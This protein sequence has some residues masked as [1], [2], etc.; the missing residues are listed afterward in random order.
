MH[1][2]EE[3]LDEPLLL[4][5]EALANALADRDDG[6]LQLDDCQRDTVDVEHHIGALPV[7]AAH[8]HLF[9][10]RK[11]VG[12]WGVPVHQPDGFVGRARRGLHLD[13][14]A[15]Q[16]IE[17]LV[18]LVERGATP[19][20]GGLLDLPHRLG[21]QCLVTAPVAQPCR[22]QLRL[23]V[24]VLLAIL[25]VAQI[26][27]AEVIPQKGDRP[28]LGVAFTF[29]N[30]THHVTSY[31]PPSAIKTTGLPMA[32]SISRLKRRRRSSRNASNASCRN[33]SGES[34][35]LASSSSMASSCN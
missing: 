7:L 26:A 32:F 19:Q 33:R 16:T 35:W 29:S 21:N 14:V 8:R 25:P 22:Q 12:L 30:L 20:R 27:I 10:Q 23:D 9:G 5:V 15:Q 6:T 3:G 24:A 18:G 28:V 13:P 1:G 2:G 31:S 11:V 4:I 17:R 34:A